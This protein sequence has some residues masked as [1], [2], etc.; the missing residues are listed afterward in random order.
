M[1][2]GRNYTLV[3]NVFT[4]NSAFWHDCMQDKQVMSY[5]IELQRWIRNHIR[6][7]TVVYLREHNILTNKREHN[8]ITNKRIRMNT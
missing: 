4:Q 1:I 3:T 5:R 2:F 6:P 8:N 7:D